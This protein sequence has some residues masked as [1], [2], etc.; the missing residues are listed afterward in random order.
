MLEGV[1]ISLCILVAYI[2]GKLM[3]VYIFAGPQTVSR[4]SQRAR[5]PASDP[6]LEEQAQVCP[7]W[8]GGDG[9][10]HAEACGGGRQGPH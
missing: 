10:S 2:S 4:S 8:S 9:N 5:V 6:D 7:Y 1:I 3:Y